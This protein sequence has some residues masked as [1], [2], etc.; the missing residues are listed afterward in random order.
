M[1]HFIMQSLSKKWKEWKATAKRQ[2][3]DP[4]DTNVERLAHCPPRVEESQWRKLV[5]YWDTADAKVCR[6]INFFS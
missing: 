6:V 4:Y 3:Y 5:Y 1:R 2:G